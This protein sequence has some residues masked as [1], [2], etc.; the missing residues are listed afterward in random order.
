MTRFAISLCCLIL[1]AVLLTSCATTRLHSKPAI[2]S[3]QGTDT[4]IPAT[5][6]PDPHKLRVMTL[7]VAH[8]RGDSFHQ[9]LQGSDTTLSN[10]DT[11]ATLM[12]NT[13]PDVVALQEADAPSFWSGNFNHVDYLARQ[14]AFRQ[15][16]H[17]SHADG[18]GLS[19]GTALIANL[20]L[21]EAEMVTFTPGL[22][23]V[24]KGFVVSTITWPGQPCID[25]DVISVHLDFAS[26]SIRRRQAGE[27][28]EKL[29]S[30]NRPVIIM[31][32]L[33][34]EWQPET[35]VHY[36]VQQLGLV[37]YRPDSD[38]L[39]TFPAFGERLDWILISP[40]LQYRSYRVI[41]D[42]V[43]DHRGVVAELTLDEAARKTAGSSDCSL[44]EASL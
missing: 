30:R 4:R 2:H 6:E 24:P 31:G 33:N 16:V 39:S 22:S 28:I 25:I 35:S 11:I 5:N 29:R 23:P 44:A 8:G 40:E 18:I 20:E 17:G 41:P 37:A 7:N 14:A 3:Y 10:L 15:S 32:D 43:S 12:K 21:S 38:E 42:V 26:Q 19:Y 34:T 36:L 13:A 27:L 1:C 9:L